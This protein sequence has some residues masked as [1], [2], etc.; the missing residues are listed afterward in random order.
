[1]RSRETAGHELAKLNEREKSQ[2]NTQK[3]L[4]LAKLQEEQKKGKYVWCYKRRAY[5]LK[6]NS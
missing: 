5:F 4:A 1:M 3:A 6:I 2:Q